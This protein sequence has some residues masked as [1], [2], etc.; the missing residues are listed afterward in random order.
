MVIGM[1]GVAI[2][3]VWAFVR[4]IS[5]V[6]YDGIRWFIS[7]IWSM[8]SSMISALPSSFRLLFGILLFY[9]LINVGV[10]LTVGSVYTCDSSG[11]IYQATNLFNGIMFKVKE[12]AFYGGS[13]IDRDVDESDIV[14]DRFD[15]DKVFMNYDGNVSYLFGLA[16]LRSIAR[17][18]FEDKV[19]QLSC[20]FTDGDIQD[21][22]ARGIGLVN[23]I[24]LVGD[25]YGSSFQGLLE[26]SSSY[27]GLTCEQTVN[28]CKYDDT[29][30]EERGCYLLAVGVPYYDGYPKIINKGFFS[31]DA[32]WDEKCDSSPPY[33]CDYAVKGECKRQKT[34]YRSVEYGES[35][36]FIGTLQ[37]NLYNDVT[38]RPPIRVRETTS[39]LDSYDSWKDF[40]SECGGF[41][42]NLTSSDLSHGTVL[43]TTVS[44]GKRV[45]LF[46][47]KAVAVQ[48]VLND[49]P[50]LLNY[51][52]SN[53][54]YPWM[55]R[56]KSIRYGDSFNPLY[57]KKGAELLQK[58]P[59]LNKGGD[60]KF[61]QANEFTMGSFINLK[62]DDVDGEK[63]LGEPMKNDIVL[64]M[65]GAYIFNFSSFMIGIG[66]F[67]LFG[68]LGF[69][70][71]HF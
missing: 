32:E 65:F 48:K 56:D 23:R 64:G 60:A 45:F 18:G 1:I 47:S 67:L 24:P 50:E 30:S 22:L 57:V 54:V 19:I 28:I 20:T 38:K 3:S 43:D 71:K 58:F 66:L 7:L 11:D 21:V 33:L 44:G 10:N 35:D 69:I 5:K 9:L 55:K 51:N 59:V 6:V 62:C 52:Y 61:E 31:S 13:S 42:D 41:E 25:V 34:V 26:L 15:V 53:T 70:L 2:V 39:W 16:G 36:E 49:N 4:G 27:G 68:L 40:L 29:I 37:Y 8:V 17:N 63:L 46:D 12:F 14:T